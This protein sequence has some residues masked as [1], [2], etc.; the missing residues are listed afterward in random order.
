MIEYFSKGS[1]ARFLHGYFDGFD[2][3]NWVFILVEVGLVQE[4]L[5]NLDIVGCL[6]SQCGIGLSSFCICRFIA[7]VVAT[8]AWSLPSFDSAF[9]TSMVVKL[10][11]FRLMACQGRIDEKIL[12]ILLAIR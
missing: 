6:A 8:G 3:N 2:A 5:Q 12:S 4:L 10:L 9:V 1:L 7:I 11:I